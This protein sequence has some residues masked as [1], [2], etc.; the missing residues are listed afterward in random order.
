[1]SARS[2]LLVASLLLLFFPNPSALG[3]RL[4]KCWTNSTGVHECG[5]KIPPEY[6]QEEHVTLNPEGVQIGH[7]EKSTTLEVYREVELRTRAIAKEE[8]EKAR[9]LK[10]DQFL[11]RLYSSSEEIIQERDE[12]LE[13]I[14]LRIGTAEQALERLKAQKSSYLENLERTQLA[15]D[16][17]R[18]KKI[19]A[20]LL[21][22]EEN[23][24]EQKNFIQKKLAEIQ[25]IQKKYDGDLERFKALGKTEEQKQPAN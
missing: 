22:T 20:Y 24:T 1:M 8:Q 7:S 6:A 18:S 19:L 21:T 16:D 9:R 4:I 11:S 5:D 15:Q 10:R 3:A 25:S 23:L 13:I 12:K 14:K 17:E 2:S